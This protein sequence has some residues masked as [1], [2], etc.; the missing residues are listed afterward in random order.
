MH[1]LIPTACLA[2]LG[3]PA[4]AAGQ[5]PAPEDQVAPVKAAPVVPQVTVNGSR[6]SDI[7]QRRNATAAKLIFGREELD[8]NGDTSIGEILKRLPGVTLGGR[9]GRGGEIRMRDLGSGYTQMLVNGERAPAGFSLDSLAPDQV[10]RIEVIRGPVAE[11]STQAIAGTI[12]IVLRE[13]YQQ[14]DVQLRLADSIEQDRHGP[15]VSVTVPGKSG[16]LTWLLNGSVFANRQRDSSSTHNDDYAANGVLEKDEV[17]D[18]TTLRHS[19]GIHLSPRLSYRFGNGDS[20]TFQPFLVHNQSNSRS[21]SELAHLGGD[22]PSEYASLAGESSASSTFLRGFGNWLR[23]M[24][25]GAKLDMKFGF[26]AARSDNTSNRREF[27]GAGSPTHLLFDRDSTRDQGL[28]TGGKYTSPLGQGHLL[29]AGWELEAGHRTQTKVALDNGHAQFVDSGANLAAD[30]RRLAGFVQDEWDITPQYAVYLGLRWEG[31]RTASSLPGGDVVNSSSV[32]SPV[33][34]GV[35]RIPGYEKDQLRGSVTQSYRAPALTDLIA[36]PSFSTDNSAARPDRVGNPQL[37]PELAKGLDLAYE[38]YL[39]RSG[40]ISVSGFSRGIDNLMRRETSYRV[41]ANG[42]RWVS[43]PVNIGHASTAGV[44]LETKFQ[45]TELVPDA[46][47]IDFRSNYSRFWSHV[48]GIPGPDNRLDQ[49]AKQ[50]ANIGVDYRMKTLP[51]TLGSSFNWTPAILVQTTTSELAST[52]DK[53]QVDVYGLWKFSA[54]TQLRVAANN[55]LHEDY[56]SGRAVA[57]QGLS[58]A[59]TL[60][61]TYTTWSIKLEMK[62]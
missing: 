37:K 45:L 54:H 14:K 2:F 26:G 6:A 22:V 16:A 9:P 60:A 43:A 35:W 11:H 58:V 4:F 13:G 40:I 46:P 47:N 12:N 28:N 8:R 61:R 1:K 7:D 3:G 30:T 32:F 17:S 34:H 18:D 50:T 24:D 29:A 38:H 44:E 42:M 15:N 5:A 10:E 51:L 25:A 57:L 20:L 19:K 27:D 36:A 52:G 59:E 62:I 31:I 56:R 53:R 33:L 55:L 41:T 39:G 23:K 48:D 49:Q 21:D